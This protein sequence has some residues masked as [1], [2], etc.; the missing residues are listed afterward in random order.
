MDFIYNYKFLLKYQLFRWPEDQST[1]RLVILNPEMR[2]KLR[3]R[4]FCVTFFYQLTTFS[5]S[6]CP[7]KYLTFS[8]LVLMISVSF[9]PSIIS[10]YTYMSTRSTQRDG[11]FFTLLPIIFAITEPLKCLEKHCT[12]LYELILEIRKQLNFTVKYMGLDTWIRRIRNPLKCTCLYYGKQGM[13][14]LINWFSS[15]T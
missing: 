5:G 8:C 9:C 12:K 6:L 10:S 7:G 11:L 14:I 13:K 15:Q 1:Q 2:L 3:A 4:I